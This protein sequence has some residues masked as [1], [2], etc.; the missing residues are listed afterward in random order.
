[1]TQVLLAVAPTIAEIAFVPKFFAEH[2]TFAIL[3]AT[4]HAIGTNLGGLSK[5]LLPSRPPSPLA[6]NVAS[7]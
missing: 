5:P 7:S 2:A 6:S 3:E 1:M 4:G